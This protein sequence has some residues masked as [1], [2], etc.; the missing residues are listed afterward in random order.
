MPGPPAKKLG[1]G[2]EQLPAGSPVERSPRAWLRP[3]PVAATPRRRRSAPAAEMSHPEFS[4]ESGW[5]RRRLGEI[6]PLSRY[7]EI[8]K[9]LTQPVEQVAHRLAGDSNGLITT[10]SC[11]RRRRGIRPARSSEDL[12]LPEAPEITSTCERSGRAQSIEDAQ[13]LG[14][15]LLAAEEHAGVLF[16]EGNKTG[17]GADIGRDREPVVGVEPERSSASRISCHARLSPSRRR[18]RWRSCRIG[19]CPAEVFAGQSPRSRC[20]PHPCRERSRLPLR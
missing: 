1:Q 17:V 9:R 8:G 14:D 2:V 20:R 13:I 16:V 5:I 18:T 10:Q 6:E 15:F 7:A 12:P 11:F 3:D 19:R 4:S